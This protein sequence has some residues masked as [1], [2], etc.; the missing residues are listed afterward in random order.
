MPGTARGSD[1]VTKARVA[2]APRLCAASSR[3]GSMARNTA[4]MVHTAGYVQRSASDQTTRLRSGPTMT[5]AAKASAA[6]RAVSPPRPRLAG[7]PPDIDE[8]RAHGEDVGD[9]AQ[10]RGRLEV[11]VLAEAVVDVDHQHLRSA[12]PPEHERDRERGEHGGEDEH[13]AH[14]QGGGG[15]GHE[16]VARDAR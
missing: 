16:D 10:R 4:A 2:D 5:Q 9:D 15:H 12:P 8:R 1:T 3:A 14:G 7:D 13:G 6:M 11:A